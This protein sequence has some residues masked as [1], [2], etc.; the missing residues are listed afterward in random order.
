MMKQIST[1]LVSAVLLLH[2]LGCSNGNVRAAAPPPPPVVEVAPVI[3]KDVPVQGEWV[4]TLEGYVNAQISPQVNG[5]L[6]RQ[7][8]H[9]GA[10]VKRVKCF[11]RSIRVHFKPCLIKPKDSWRRLRHRWRT[12]KRT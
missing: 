11:L 3:Q 4:G 6:I 12:P 7:D 8:Y 9:E 2:A 1:A 10:F 5:Y